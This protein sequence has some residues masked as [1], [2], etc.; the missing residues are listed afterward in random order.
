MGH[1]FLPY[2]VEALPL[3]QEAG[4]PR[5]D[6]FV[7]A[8]AAAVVSGASARFCCTVLFSSVFKMLP[9]APTD[10]WGWGTL[11]T[12]IKGCAPSAHQLQPQ[13]TFWVTNPFLSR[14]GYWGVWM[15][16]LWWKGVVQVSVPMMGLC[17]IEVLGD[18]SSWQCNLL[19]TSFLLQ[20]NHPKKTIAGHYRKLCLTAPPPSR[21]VRLHGSIALFYCVSSPPS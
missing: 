20:K 13:A 1:C 15:P 5:H 16:V 21:H 19:Y 12:R 9:C 17:F 18:L 14:V 7:P 11:A 4:C 2:C 8:L 10:V 6:Y 3:P